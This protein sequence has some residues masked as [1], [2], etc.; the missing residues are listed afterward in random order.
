SAGSVIA[1]SGSVCA[2]IILA[3]APVDESG[4]AITSDLGVGVFAIAIAAT[5][6]VGFLIGTLHAWLI[7]VVGLPP[8]VATL[9]SLVGLRSLARVL[10]PEV[11]AAVFPTQSNSSQIYIS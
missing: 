9:A 8:F 11:N 2:S 3:L 4:N 7:T 6:V 1:F 10:V 5:L